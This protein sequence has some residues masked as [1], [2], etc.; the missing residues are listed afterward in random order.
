VRQNDD[1]EDLILFRSEDSGARRLIT[2]AFF[3]LA[4]QPLE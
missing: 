2:G 1:E 4:D 3:L